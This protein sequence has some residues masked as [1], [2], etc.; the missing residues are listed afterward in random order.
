[1]PSVLDLAARLSDAMKD[2]EFR[3]HPSRIAM[4]ND[5]GELLRVRW[6]LM[7]SPLNDVATE[8]AF[9][10]ATR[11]CRKLHLFTKAD[12]GTTRRVV[13]PGA[14]SERRMRQAILDAYARDGLPGARRTA[15]RLH[16]PNGYLQ[17]MVDAIRRT[18]FRKEDAT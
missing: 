1:M 14:T 9:V 7:C 8:H 16:G 10:A 2:T 11:L 12:T 15:E 18:P 17:V 6:S 13:R 4:Q 3:H 5:V